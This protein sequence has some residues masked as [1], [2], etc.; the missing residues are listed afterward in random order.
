MQ[1]ALSIRAFF[2]SNFFFVLLFLALV[3]FC[4]AGELNPGPLHPQPQYVFLF[5]FCYLASLYLVLVFRDSFLTGGKASPQE[6]SL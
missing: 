2:P 6:F 1:Y 3:V 5:V 4:S